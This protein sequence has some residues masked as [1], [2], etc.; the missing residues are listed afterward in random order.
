MTQPRLFPQPTTEVLMSQKILTPVSLKYLV[1]GVIESRLPP[2]LPE[3]PMPS[4]TLPFSWV[5]HKKKRRRKKRLWKKYVKHPAHY[6]R[7]PVANEYLRKRL[8]LSMV[9]SLR[10]RLD[11]QGIARKAFSMQ[12]LPSK[13]LQILEQ[14]N[15]T[16]CFKK[17][18]QD[19]ILGSKA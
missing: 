9:R 13:A 11:Y 2:V 18:D 8:A 16:P 1:D 7:G 14:K 10:Q 19:S 12:P 15:D 4:D 3:R 17:V 6:L 5:R